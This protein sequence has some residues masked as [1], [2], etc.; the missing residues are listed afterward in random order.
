MGNVQQITRDYL[1]RARTEGVAETTAAA[2]RLGSATDALATKT[3]TQSKSAISA[4]AALER[5]QRQ[6]DLNYRSMKQFEQ[7]QR[8]LDRAQQQGLIS[9]ARH[10]ELMAS[11]TQ[12]YGQAST[13]SKAL[14]A[15]TSGVSGQLI[16]LSAGAGPVGVFLSALGPWGIAAAAA[17]GLVGAAFHFVA[18]ESAR[19]GTKAIELN[20]F[21]EV[22]G[23]TIAQIGA[24]R[25]SGA[26]LGIAG[27]TVSGSFGRLTSQLTE[28]RRASGSLYDDVRLV[29]GGLANELQ[30]TT[31]TAGGINALAK[32]YQQ[33]GD[34]A[35]KASIARA[36]FGRGGAGLGPVL[37]AIADAG[38]IDE[39]AKHTKLLGE[40]MD[41]QN[42][43]WAKMQAQIEETN[44]R[45]KNILATVFTEEGLKAALLAAEY[46][47]R[48]AKAAAEVAQQRE[49]L[50]WFQ[51]FFA[52]AAKLT[53]GEH[54]I[55]PAVI[56]QQM[57]T[58]AAR[59]RL[60]Q[61]GQGFAANK[62]DIDSWGQLSDKLRGIKT[63]A[64]EAAQSMKKL[65][66]D[67]AAS[68]KVERDRIGLLGAAATVDEQ[69]NARLKDLKSALL[70]NRIAEQDYFRAVSATNIDAR[71][72]KD[73]L[74]LGQLGELATVVDLNK[75]KEDALQKTIR[76]GVQFSDA[77][78]AAIRERNK[79]L[80]ES[81][82]IENQMVFDRQQIFKTQ[83]D[84]SI[85]ALLRANGIP[86]ASARAE[87][88]RDYMR[89]TDALKEMGDAGGQALATFA[90]TFAE[91]RDIAKATEAAAKGLLNTIIDASAKRVVNIGLNAA[92]GDTVGMTAG[93]STAAGILTTAGTTV[94]ASIIAGA[95]EAAAILGLTVPAAAASLPV[96]G[97]VTGT[98]VAAGGI[99]GGV[100]L[101]AGGT[102]AATAIYGPIAILV[103]AVAAL[104][105]MS[106]FGG[107]DG[108]QFVKNVKAFQD[109]LRRQFDYGTRQATAQSDG[110]LASQLAL[111]DRDAAKQRFEELE[112]GGLAINQ[113][114]G[115]L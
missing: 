34:Q 28:A 41:A 4:A 105:A 35:Q 50:S 106:L 78:L 51:K 88:I 109:A 15:A 42:A 27:D 16:A 96:A 32:A 112:K 37:G 9:T 68:A 63:P 17:L 24:L 100:G 20:Q 98:E 8:D 95:T 58:F 19:M 80:T 69:R 1:L 67:A 66:D 47:E 93:A 79:L 99:A 108:G 45:A 73:A 7:S 113:L 104:G 14:Q 44:K 18:E 5:Q 91:T 30:N 72:Q 3:E 94:A 107:G 101:A 59:Q 103:A 60:A 31:D 90:K 74:R 38:G 64:E 71:V 115:A 13:A 11:A 97:G 36:V 89:M 49:G 10:A 40:A 92:F 39:L 61:G 111:F 52:D 77:E 62:G 114:E 75:Q 29:S 23:L 81:S 70:D 21:K 86:P 26:E 12:K 102:A 25:H 43:R 55:D 54:G 2:Q 22:T 33:A 83:V 110:S 65:Q 46:M 48:M 76:E 53:A 82:K 57:A 56:D 6:L 85:D 84:Q 87:A